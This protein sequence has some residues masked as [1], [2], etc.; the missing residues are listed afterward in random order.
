MF[1]SVWQN[2]RCFASVKCITFLFDWYVPDL[3]LSNVAQ[4]LNVN[5]QEI[6]TLAGEGGRRVMPWT[7]ICGKR[8]DARIMQACDGTK[9]QVGLRF[10]PKGFIKGKSA[11]D[12]TYHVR[13]G[14][15]QM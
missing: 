14:E 13:G 7:E 3:K 9:T 15:V 4:N 1:E 12:K 6:V 5:Q 8:F 2:V 10:G 11:T